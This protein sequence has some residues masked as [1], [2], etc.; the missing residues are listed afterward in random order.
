MLKVNKG[1]SFLHPVTNQMVGPGQLYEDFRQ[2]SKEETIP[3]QTE[4][5]V[6][7]NKELTIEEG[8]N[9]EPQEGGEIDGQ[10]EDAGKAPKRNRGQSRTVQDGESATE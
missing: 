1:S 9:Q 10:S 7:E 3:E 4:N 2:E 5:K 6:P 8:N